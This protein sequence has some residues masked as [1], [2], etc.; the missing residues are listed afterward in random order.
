MP[1]AEVRR[2]DGRRAGAVVLVA[3]LGA[4]TLADRPPPAPG[5]GDGAPSASGLRAVSGTV[6]VTADSVN[7]RAGPG[8]GYTVIGGARRGDRLAVLD[9]RG[10]WLEIR[11]PRGSA[12]I[13]A[14]LTGPPEGTRRSAPA[15]EETAENPLMAPPLPE[16]ARQLD[17]EAGPT[18]DEAIEQA[19]GAPSGDPSPSSPT[20][21]VDPLEDEAG[22]LP[23]F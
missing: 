1:A 9:R 2:R 6:A 16:T 12:W 20:E 15:G 23:N 10:A 17:G 18:P 7:L 13:A 22:T 14:R 11:R 19:A 3:I 8:T 21:A 5:G 4:C